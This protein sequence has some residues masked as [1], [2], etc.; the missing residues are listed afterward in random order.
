MATVAVEREDRD[1]RIAPAASE[2]IDEDDVVR[3]LFRGCSIPEE[4][5]SETLGELRAF[6]FN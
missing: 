4:D 5:L 2:A 1:E 3:R 6:L